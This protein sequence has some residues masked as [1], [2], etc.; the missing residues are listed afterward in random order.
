MAQHIANMIKAPRDFGMILPELC[1]IYC[2]R[3]FGGRPR[4]WKIRQ[5]TKN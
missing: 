4:F 3:T 5:F 2:Q 1:F